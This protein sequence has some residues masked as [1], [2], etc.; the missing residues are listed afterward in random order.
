MGQPLRGRELISVSAL[1]LANAVPLAGVLFFGWQVFPLILLFWL[2]NVIV[3]GFNVLK[4]LT[5]NPEDPISWVGK[6]FLIPFFCVHFGGFTFIHGTFVFAMFGGPAYS[7][8]FFPS[9]AGV[10][11][12]IRGTGIRLGVLGLVLSHGVSF[13]GNYLIGGEY[14]RASLQQLMSQPYGRV[15]VMHFVILGGGFLVVALH[16]PVP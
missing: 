16:S 14:R 6:A 9:V 10:L 1:I 11:A 2:E 4:M 8:Q 3:G 15:M 12:A 7:H 5:A 13:V